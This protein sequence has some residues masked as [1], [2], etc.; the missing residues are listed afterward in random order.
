MEGFHAKMAHKK[1]REGNA[2]RVSHSKNKQVLEPRATYWETPPL[3]PQLQRALPCINCRQKKKKKP[4]SL[5][6][7]GGYPWYL[8][9]IMRNK[10]KKRWGISRDKM[11][12]QAH[13]PFFENALWYLQGRFQS[14]LHF[15]KF[16]GTVF[17]RQILMGNVTKCWYI[18]RKTTCFSTHLNKS[19]QLLSCTWGQLVQVFCLLHSNVEQ[20]LVTRFKPF[21]HVLYYFMVENRLYLNVG[22][23]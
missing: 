8:P 16:L 22:H 4:F 21:P 7:P 12:L 14:M 3:L 13:C 23:W 2:F 19:S 11:A 9:G 20:D 17:A 18:K 10:W 1:C 15:L 5:V 6:I